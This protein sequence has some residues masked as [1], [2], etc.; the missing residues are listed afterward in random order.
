MHRIV[1]RNEQ[2]L[3][4]ITGAGGYEE[5]GVSRD[6]VSRIGHNASIRAPKD[7]ASPRRP[8]RPS[9]KQLRIYYSSLL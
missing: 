7:I 9:G 2:R 5:S 4:K 1:T 6:G 3:A 8:L